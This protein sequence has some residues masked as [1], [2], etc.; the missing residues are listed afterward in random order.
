MYYF[1]YTF[2]NMANIGGVFPRT[3]KDEF[4]LGI[5]AFKELYLG[6]VVDPEL[7]N[8][9]SNYFIC[10][11]DEDVAEGFKI[12]SA[13]RLPID[14]SS[15]ESKSRDLT[16]KELALQAKAKALV[17]KLK[18]RPKI[19]REIGDIN[20]MVADM[21]K[22]IDLLEKILLKTTF[23]LF[24]DTEIPQAMKDTY[25][26]MITK[27]I[28]DIEN[29]TIKAKEDLEDPQTLFDKL[30]ARKSTIAKIVKSEYLDK[31]NR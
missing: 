5:S 6:T 10:F 26:P 12:I 23:F 15:P 14:P 30:A 19:Y 2:Q 16:E 29:D 11:I 8:K 1:L 4:T 31:I 17:L 25:L 20:D 9:I 3:E 24:Q 28:S 22:R 18:L 7:I 21:S 27:Y 13:K